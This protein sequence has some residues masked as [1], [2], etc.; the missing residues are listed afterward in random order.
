MSKPSQRKLEK[1]RRSEQRERAHQA[2][3]LASDSQSLAYRGREYRTERH[4]PWLLQAE[5]AIYEAFVMSDRSLTDHEVAA[6][7]EKMIGKLRSEAIR[8]QTGPDAS[9]PEDEPQGKEAPLDMVT[10]NIEQRWKA[11]AASHSPPGG[12]NGLIGML[13]TILGSVEN[14]KTMD[15]DSRGYLAFISIFMVKAGVKV[16]KVSAAEARRLPFPP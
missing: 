2:R 10:W 12:R 5:L 15:A 14:H 9:R 7:L 8:D 1:K 13:R 4:L 6:S 11:M 3:R 16:R